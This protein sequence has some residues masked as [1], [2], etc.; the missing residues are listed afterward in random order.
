MG[1]AGWGEAPPLAGAD[2]SPVLLAAPAS[3]GG[4]V[5]AARV[6][7]TRTMLVCEDFQGF[8]VLKGDS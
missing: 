7:T 8:G 3:A 5:S 1:G 6:T 2:V 4:P